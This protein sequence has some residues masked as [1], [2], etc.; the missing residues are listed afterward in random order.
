MTEV[1]LVVEV[2]PHGEGVAR[3]C[4]TRERAVEWATAHRPLRDLDDYLEVRAYVVDPPEPDG[5]GLRR[6]NPYE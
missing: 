1:W 6:W 5:D 4:S 3:V 2:T